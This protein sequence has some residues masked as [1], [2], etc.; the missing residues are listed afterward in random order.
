LLGA[1]GERLRLFL[2]MLN[3]GAYQSDISDL[4]YDGCN[5]AGASD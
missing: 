3:T 2:L 4:G 5:R 1:A